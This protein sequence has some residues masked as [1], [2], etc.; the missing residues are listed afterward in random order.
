MIITVFTA[1]KLRH[2]YLIYK[3]SKSAEKLFVFQEEK[4]KKKKK[5]SYIIKYLKKVSEA[6][7]K[8]FKSKKKLQANTKV[9]KLKYGDLGNLEIKKNLEFFQSDLYVVFGTSI[10]KGKLLNFLLKKKAINIHMGVSPYYNG[11]DCNFWAIFD[12]NKHLVGGTLQSLSKKVDQGNIIS[13]VKSRVKK[14]IYDF[15][16]ISVKLIIDKLSNI[17][18]N[19]TILSKKRKKQNLR[20]NIRNTKS[21]HFTNEVVKKFFDSKLKI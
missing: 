15:S 11:T 16:M 1:N 17:V 20:K 21:N 4:R 6:E 8:I 2:E 12:N 3:L 10:I 5:G 13:V 7:R 18:I 19:K 9:I 14:N